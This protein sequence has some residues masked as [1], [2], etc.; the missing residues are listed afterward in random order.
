M[1]YIPHGCWSGLV[2]CGNGIICLCWILRNVRDHFRDWLEW[3]ARISVA[4]Y[5]NPL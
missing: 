3:C 4:M 5:N 1:S 2:D